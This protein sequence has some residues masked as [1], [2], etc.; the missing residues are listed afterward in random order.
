[1]RW[2]LVDQIVEC[3]AGVS[4]IGVKAFSRSD[5]FFMDHFPGFPIVPGAMQIEMMAQMGGKII[6]LHKVNILPVL[7]HVKS[8][9]FY[10]NIGPGELCFIHIQVEKIAKTWATVT[11]EVRVRDLKVS[12]AHILFGL[13]DRSLLASNDFDLVT[14]DWV[15]KKSQEPS[16]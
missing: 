13:I 16:P 12:S 3:T 6:A 4:G 14:Q 5:L 11:G 7:G 15:K 1:M 9:K 2:L 10:R 8:A